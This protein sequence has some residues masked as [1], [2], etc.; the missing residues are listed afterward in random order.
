MRTITHIVVHCTATPQTTT[1]ESIQ[2]HWRTVLGWRS[3]GYHIL[4]TPSGAALRLA[5]DSATTNGVRGH[6]ATSLHVSYIGG[7]DA[8]GRPRDN[9]TAEQKA[10]MLRVITE[11]RSLYGGAKVCGHRDFA[12]VVK[13][14][15][16][17][18]AIAEYRHL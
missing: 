18:D 16:S 7:V 6:N 10:T 14:C 13:A 9:R 2:R 12:G 15:P 5:P 11:W 17:F 4:V 1:V 8:Q 3:P